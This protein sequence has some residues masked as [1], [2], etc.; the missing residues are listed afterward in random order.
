MVGGAFGEVGFDFD[1]DGDLGVG[2]G[3][4]VGDDL[5][6]DLA[7][8]AADAGWV[9]FDRAVVAAV[10]RGL[11]PRLRRVR[12]GSRFGPRPRLRQR[13]SDRGFGLASVSLKLAVGDVGFDDEA[14]VVG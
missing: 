11:R 1:G 10:E 13:R 14:G 3:D 5:L 12:V 2:E 6:G 7:G 8:V 4:Q 9:E